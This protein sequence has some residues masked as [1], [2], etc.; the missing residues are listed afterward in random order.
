MKKI[1][2]SFILN[3]IIFLLLISGLVLETFEYV[4]KGYDLSFLIFRFKYFTELSNV[5]AG[6][7]SLVYAYYLYKSTKKVEIPSLLK[8][9][10][11]M[12][13]GGVIVT[14]LTVVFYLIPVMGNEWYKLLVGSQFLFHLVIPV[15]SFITYLFFED[16]V[17]KSKYILFNLIPIVLYGLFYLLVATSHVVDG[18]IDIEYDWY[19][20][21]KNGIVVG[22]LTYVFFII[23]NIAL[24]YG[25][26]KLNKRINSK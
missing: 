14:F 24:V 13:T 26:N 1:N 16:N 6:V 17:V 21:M 22:L 4:F 8:L 3:I 5:F 11:L 20:F 18:K 9:L 19:L 7:T 10:K 12:S 15:L 23:F 2:I 25:L